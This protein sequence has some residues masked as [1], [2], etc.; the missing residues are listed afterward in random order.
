MSLPVP[1]PFFE[2][3]SINGIYVIS[4]DAILYIGLPNSSK[5]STAVL[6]NGDEKHIN[7]S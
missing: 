1:L 6:S 5:K 2:I 4:K 7:P 3:Y